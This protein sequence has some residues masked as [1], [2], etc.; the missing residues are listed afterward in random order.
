PS[1][2]HTAFA[3][4]RS[5]SI[6]FCNAPNLDASRSF[7]ASISRNRA[8][9]QSHAWWWVT[10]GLVIAQCLPRQ[11][12][13]VIRSRLPFLIVSPFLSFPRTCSLLSATAPTRLGP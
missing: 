7:S 11:V 8:S 10:H 4:E 1:P 6:A 3:S 12:K 9:R 5:A 2:P 13:H